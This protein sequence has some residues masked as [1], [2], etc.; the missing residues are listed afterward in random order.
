L[1]FD[2][3]VTFQDKDASPDL[4]FTKPYIVRTRLDENGKQRGK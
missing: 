4:K 2:K 3:H 1:I